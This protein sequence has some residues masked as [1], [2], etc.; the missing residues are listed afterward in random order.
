MTQPRQR[1]KPHNWAAFVLIVCICAPLTLASA[2]YYS[3]RPNF[4][5]YP[6]QLASFLAIASALLIGLSGL[7]VGV[8]HNFKA[9][10]S[11]FKAG[12]ATHFRALIFT[13]GSPAVFAL[14]AYLFFN[15]PFVYAMHLISVQTPA[16][17]TFSVTSALGGGRRCRNSATIVSSSPSFTGKVCGLKLEDVRRLRSGGE[18]ELQGSESLYGFAY[19]RYRTSAM[20]ANYAIKVTAE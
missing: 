18:I 6:N 20:R 4:I 11:Y 3:F 16:S 1:M 5:A 14:P 9:I 8:V 2:V 19:S 15:S 10:R 13:L 12:Q 7:A 17:R